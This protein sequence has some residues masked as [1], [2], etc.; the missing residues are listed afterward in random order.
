MF[1]ISDCIVNKVIES[2]IQPS[3]CTD[4]SLISITLEV[5]NVKRGPGVWKFNDSLLEDKDFVEKLTTMLKGIKR[6]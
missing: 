3:I 4:H 1:L 6:I 5:S 2:K